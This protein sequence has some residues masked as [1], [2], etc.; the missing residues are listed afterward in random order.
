MTVAEINALLY[1]PNHPRERLQDALR[2]GHFP[3]MAR[4]VRGL[5]ARPQLA[6]RRG[7]AGLVQPQPRIRWRQDSGRSWS[8]RSIGRARTSLA[9]AA[10]HR[11]SAAA[12]RSP[13][14]STSSCAS[15]RPP[16][17]GAFS[18]TRFRPLSTERYRISV[19]IEPN[20]AVGTYLRAHLQVGD[21]STS[22]RRGDVHPAGR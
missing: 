20:G 1:S 8:R 16:V 12:N 9:D 19:K 13:Q 6:R 5:A 2:I 10:R 11:G 18:P 17:A 15:D 14:A 21:Y 22:A 7:N 3:R 4:L